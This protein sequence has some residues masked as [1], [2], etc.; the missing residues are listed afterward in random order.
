MAGEG[1]FVLPIGC[2]G[3]SQIGIADIR[4]RSIFRGIGEEVIVGGV[5]AAFLNST[6]AAVGK[7]RGVIG[8]DDL[9]LQRYVVPCAE[10]V[11]N[12]YVNSHKQ[13]VALVHALNA[14]GTVLEGKGIGSA[15]GSAVGGDIQRAVIICGA[16]CKKIGFG[17]QGIPISAARHDIKLVDHLLA[18]RRRR[19]EAIAQLCVIVIV[20][21]GYG[22]CNLDVVVGAA[23]IIGLAGFLDAFLVHAIFVGQHLGVAPVGGITGKNR[24]VIGANDIHV[25]GVVSAHGGAAVTQVVNI[26]VFQTM[27]VLHG[28]SELQVHFLAFSKGVGFASGLSAAKCKRIAAR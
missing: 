10:F 12:N 21:G 8:A 2:G 16:Q 3:V 26:K 27:L 1:Q 9:K 15:V 14:G 6:R 25:N 23:G 19:L 20:R 24:A 5:D 28:R 7:V 4:G 17:K 18:R 11:L 13:G 22:A